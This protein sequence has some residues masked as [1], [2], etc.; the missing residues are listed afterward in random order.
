MMLFPH[1]L[2]DCLIDAAADVSATPILLDSP[3]VFDATPTASDVVMAQ[4]GTP[5]STASLVPVSHR[6]SSLIASSST[7]TVSASSPERP[8]FASSSKLKKILPRVARKPAKLDS[9]LSP[10]LRKSTDPYPVGKPT[11]LAKNSGTL[12]KKS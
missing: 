3:S 7:P 12:C 11:I 4:L 6:Q 9:V 10:P 2:L 5:S 1:L 8:A